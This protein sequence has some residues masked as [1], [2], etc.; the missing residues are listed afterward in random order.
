MPTLPTLIDGNTATPV[1]R[2]IGGAYHVV[3][4]VYVN[5]GTI[6]SLAEGFNDF[7]VNAAAA[8]AAKDEAEVFRDETNANAAQTTLDVIQ[9]AEDVVATGLLKDAATTQAGLTAEDR[10][11]TGLDR[12]QTGLD[13][14][15]TAEDRV[16]TGLDVIATSSAR[17]AALAIGYVYPHTTAGLAGTTNG[18]YFNVISPSTGGTIDLY[19]NNA[20]VADYKKTYPSTL[21]ISLYRGQMTSG[22]SMD[23]YVLPG[24]WYGAPSAGYT[25][26]PSGMSTSLSFN[27][28]VSETYGV[29]GRFVLQ[30]IRLFATPTVMYSRR[31]DNTG[32]SGQAWKK[33]EL[34]EDNSVT[35]TKLNSVFDYIS[36]L[37]TNVGFNDS[38]LRLKSGI[39]FVS[40]AQND[41]P[42]NSASSGY[43]EVKKYGSDWGLQY[44]TELLTTKNSWVRAFRI[45]TDTFYPWTKNGDSSFLGTIS[46]ATTL[47]DYTTQSGSYLVTVAQTD[48]PENATNS[49]YFDVSLHGDWVLQTYRDLL[50]PSNVW[51]RT[52]RISTSIAYDWGRVSGRGSGA[53]D[54][55]ILACIGDSITENGDWPSRVATKLGLTAY[56]YGFG[57]CRM[58]KHSLTTQGVIYNK[59]CFFN[60]ARYINTGVYTELIAAAD[61]LYAENGDDNRVQA[62]AFAATDWSTVDY[63]CVAFGT[64]DFQGDVPI[65]TIADNLSDGSTFY[66]AIN[67]AIQQILSVYPHIKIMFVSPMWRQRQASGDNKDSNNYPNNNGAYLYD[68][69]DAVINAANRQQLSAFDLYRNSGVNQYN[70]STYLVDGLHPTTGVGYQLVADKIGSFIASNF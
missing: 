65:G 27:M 51:Q 53:F 40:V 48:K 35:S 63:I 14:V 67:Y 16:Q 56:N 47:A 32:G 20:G 69:A 12:V 9:T 36:A 49:G 10:V 25:D 38:S 44:Y 64:N 43:F 4:E 21:G 11:Q 7:E 34:L 37:S 55:K 42:T 50:T 59:M 70:Y 31:Y 28:F 30:E 17:D 26:L 2:I 1:D 33:T 54:G 66:G 8:I 23:A 6:K 41:R 3:K 58:G 52:V 39:Y 24:V 15:A 22:T 29:S 13:A 19:L 62:A 5:L 57:G 46:T 68:F 45:S 18:E 61:A 60:L